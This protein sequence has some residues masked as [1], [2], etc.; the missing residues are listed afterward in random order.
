L[1]I[2]RAR[3]MPVILAQD[4]LDRLLR[5]NRRFLAGRA[6][7]WSVTSDEFRKMAVG[8]APFAV[9]LGCSDS[10]VP[11]EIVFDQGPG[12]LFVIRVAGN[13]VAPSQMASVEFAVEQFGIRLV[14]VLGHTQCGAVR[15]TLEHLRQGQSPPSGSL[16]AI[17]QRIQPS[18][19]GVVRA[20]PAQDPDTLWREAVR[21]NVRAAVQELRQGSDV[22]RRLSL[23]HGLL[24]AGAEY[25]VE[26]GEVAFFDP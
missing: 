20:A 19:E 17:L 13:I 14:V 16:A 9:V 18:V 26:T 10:R 5:G 12:D 21:A 22:L 2:P 23:E 4:A 11:V 1:E 8:Q 24:V 15:L 3:G 7:S 6:R 25:A